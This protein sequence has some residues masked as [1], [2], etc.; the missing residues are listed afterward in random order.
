MNSPAIYGILNN[1]EKD[2]FRMILEELAHHLALHEGVH[3]LI[4]DPYQTLPTGEWA[5]HATGSLKKHVKKTLGGRIPLL[6][7]EQILALSKSKSREPWEMFQQAVSFFV[8]KPDQLNSLPEAPFPVIFIVKPESDSTSFLFECFN[9]IK[10]RWA[11]LPPCPTVIWNKDHIEK[12]AETFVEI[13]SELTKVTKVRPP[14]EF[15]GNLAVSLEKVQ[16][17]RNRPGLSLIETFPEDQFHGQI[18]RLFRGLSRTP[19]V[20]STKIVES[21][22]E[23]SA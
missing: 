16:V 9:S 1:L 13:V 12:A 22:K 2:E 18:R 11:T 23:T 6:G 15:L 8:L 14:F 17:I 3:P 7:Q 5:P 10:K 19:A 4:V 20:F 21:L